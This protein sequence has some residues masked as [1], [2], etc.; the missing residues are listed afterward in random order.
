MN[1]ETAGL[2]SGIEALALGCDKMAVLQA[3]L[4]HTGRTLVSLKH[5]S[6]YIELDDPAEPGCMR[7]LTQWEITND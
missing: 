7:I 5:Q 1:N 6:A 3:L 4:Y 2:I